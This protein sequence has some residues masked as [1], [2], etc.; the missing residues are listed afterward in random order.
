MKSKLYLVALCASVFVSNIVYADN[1]PTFT[2]KQFIDASRGM[3][4]KEGGP[5]FAFPDGIKWRIL[6]FLD[7]PITSFTEKDTISPP[8]PNPEGVC[9]YTI[10]IPDKYP[11]Q[12]T[13]Q[14]VTPEPIG[15]AH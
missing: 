14:K 15:R 10:T 13:L 12:M 8:T 4:S 3:I 11:I 2:M 6:H 1:C 9:V 7:V 5:I